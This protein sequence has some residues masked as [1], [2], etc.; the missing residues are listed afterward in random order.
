MLPGSRFGLLL[1]ATTC[2]VLGLAAWG[3]DR[4]QTIRWVGA[5]HLDV[6]FLVTDADSGQPV[7]GACIHVWSEGGF[8]DG[9]WEKDRGKLFELRTDAAGRVC[10]ECRNNR[11]S[12]TQSRL[13]FTNSYNV[14]IPSWSLRVSAEGY[15]PSTWVDLEYAG[16][17]VRAGPERDVLMVHVVLKKTKAE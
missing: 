11:C 15:Q 2:P 3:F 10:R 6:Q 4:S 9:A 1:L 7:Q 12:G 13:R 17:C 14:T 16:K 8:Y 5:T